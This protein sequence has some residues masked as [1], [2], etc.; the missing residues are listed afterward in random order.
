MVQESVM[1]LRSELDNL[2]ALQAQGTIS[3]DEFEAAKAR[4]LQDEPRSKRSTGIGDFA[5][6]VLVM[7]IL[8]VLGLGVL[9]WAGATIL[10]TDAGILAVLGSTVILL[11]FAVIATLPSGR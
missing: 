6:F 11:L 4:L 8:Y 1:S 10:L 7:L 2:K 5:R 9:G 3:G